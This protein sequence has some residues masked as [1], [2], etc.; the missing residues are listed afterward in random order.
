M[1]K[2]L[3]H[4][5]QSA[6]MDLHDDVEFASEW[7]TRSAKHQPKKQSKMLA[8]ASVEEAATA[9]YVS[10]YR[11]EKDADERRTKAATASKLVLDQRREAHSIARSGLEAYNSANPVVDRGAHVAAASSVVV[12]GDSEAV[13]ASREKFG[14][15]PVPATLPECQAA[16][17]RAFTAGQVRCC[18]V[19]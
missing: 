16:F 14:H 1:G 6:S 17:T 10:S 12:G 13:I 2:S 7:T 5:P 8:R 11:K 9:A 3:V 15:E 4:P 18:V 19:Q